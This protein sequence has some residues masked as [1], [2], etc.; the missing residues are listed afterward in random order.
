MTNIV[1]ITSQGQVTI[2]AKIRRYLGLEKYKKASIRAESGKVII[3]PLP[4]L[5]GLGGSLK[6]KALKN[7][8]ISEIIKLEE[9]AIVKALSKKTSYN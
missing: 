5:L 4:D 9:K 7:K 8:S 3:E 2:P 6:Q 1:S